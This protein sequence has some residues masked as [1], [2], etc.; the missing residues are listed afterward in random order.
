MS[1]TAIG[2]LAAAAIVAAGA[3]GFLLFSG[4]EDGGET[5]QPQSNEQAPSQDVSTAEEDASPDESARE[6]EAFS[7]SPTARAIKEIAPDYGVDGDTAVRCM[8]E[9]TVGGFTEEEL[10]IIKEDPTATSWPPGLAEKYA[11][12]LES[13]IPLDPWYFE[14]FDYYIYTTPGC[15]RAMTDYVLNVY[16]WTEFILKGVMGPESKQLQLEKEFENYVELGY[17]VNKCYLDPNSPQP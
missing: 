4:D 13:C 15:P 3:I 5:A 16:N 12:V 1:K 8:E 6:A 11:A 7:D 10:A 2:L 14:R 17:E 9:N